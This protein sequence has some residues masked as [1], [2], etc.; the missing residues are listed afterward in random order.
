MSEP[1]ELFPLNI[2]NVTA[3]GLSYQTIGRRDQWGNLLRFSAL[4]TIR[5]ITR[6][7]YDVYFMKRGG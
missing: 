5:G 3:I 2:V 7:I 6:P 4:A 1:S